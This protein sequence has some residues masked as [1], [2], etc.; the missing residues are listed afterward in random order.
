MLVLVLL[1]LLLL[2]Q[3]IPLSPLTVR[4]S[5]HVASL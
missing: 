5:M 1:L 4:C 3:V 2:V